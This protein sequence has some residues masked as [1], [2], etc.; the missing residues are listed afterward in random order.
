M[1]T[2]K[3]E[4]GQYLLPKNSF[5]YHNEKGLFVVKPKYKVG[6][7]LVKQGYLHVVTE[8]EDSNHTHYTLTDQYGDRLSVP[9]K[10]CED[11]YTIEGTFALIEE[12][13]SEQRQQLAT[14]IAKITDKK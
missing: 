3:L 6:D 5:V 12:L 9:F 1:D 14:F 7:V 10:R 2:I 13:T 8:I 11:N 4:Y